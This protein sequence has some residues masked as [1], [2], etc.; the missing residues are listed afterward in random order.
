MDGTGAIDHF[1]KA[2]STL[3]AQHLA[4]I[5]GDKLPT[6]KDSH[7]VSIMTV[8]LWY[9]FDNIVPS[10]LGYLIPSSTPR[11]RNPERALGV[12]LDSEVGVGANPKTGPEPGTKL[13]VL[14]GGH[15]YDEPGASI[16][17]EEEAIQQAKTLLERQLRI[18]RDLPCHA[19]ASLAPECLP[20]HYVGHHRRMAAASNELEVGFN[21][22]LA[23]IGGSYRSPGL[24]GAARAGYDI[25]DSVAGRDFFDNGLQALT[26]DKV[27][28]PEIAFVPPLWNT[29]PPTLPQQMYHRN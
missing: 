18:P 10:G 5:T 17:S 28:N 27:M 21:N 11:E 6:L 24:L 23:A 13:F 14:L 1:D 15:Y 2:I 25:A 26:H 16:P 3:P 29:P 7:S 22:R 8:N 12:F 9:P 19:V 4:R 20:Q